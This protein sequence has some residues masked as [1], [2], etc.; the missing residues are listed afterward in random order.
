M[1]SNFNLRAIISA[2][3]RLSPILKAQQRQINAWK[4]SFASAGKGALPMAAGLAAA[5]TL[6]AKAFMD[7]E[8]AA[9]ALKN[10]LMTKDGLSSGFE[11]LTKIATDLGNKLPGTTADF[12]QM[13]TVMKSNGMLTNTLIN[14]GLKSAA[15]LAVATQ[16]LGETYDSAA[17]GISKISNV[18]SVADKDFVAL[19]DTMQRVANIG[20]GIEPFTSAMSKAGGVLKGL[21]ISGL[22]AAKAVA[23]LVAIMT[24]AGIDPSEAGTGLKEAFAVI[25]GAGKYK[26]VESMVTALQKLY[27]TNP[28]KLVAAYTKMFGKEHATKLIN[29]AKPGEYEKVV[30]EMDNQ[31]SLNMRIAESLKS[32]TNLV[33]AASGTM[34]NTMSAFGNIYAPEMKETADYLNNLADK[35]GVFI[36]KNG[37]FIKTA[38][39]SAAAFVGLKLAFYGASVALGVLNGVM[40]ANP[41]MLLIQGLALAAPLIYNHWGEITDFVKTSFDTAITWVTD[42]FKNFIDGIKSGFEAIKSMWHGISGIFSSNS[43]EPIFPMPNV[44]ESVIK[45]ASPAK[46]PE[47]KVFGN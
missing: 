30:K 25:G 12:T 14:G 22:G 10:V 29:I 19:A 45:M 36:I 31:A 17:L 26:S 23:P 11:E 47:E 24:R 20:V 16:G 32:L 27:K 21:Q 15:Y 13:A 28:N 34:T 1:A 2:T 44:P 6:P 46:L 40:K 33:D 3:D 8:N 37:P 4:R 38:L 35:L 39:K 9:I 7:A 18:F 43:D 41:W 5:I 42:K